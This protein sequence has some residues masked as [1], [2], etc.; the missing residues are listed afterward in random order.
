MIPLSAAQRRLWLID[1][2]EST[3]AAYN[4]PVLLHLHGRVDVAAWRAALVDV[5][6]RHEALRTC[7]ERRAN[8]LIQIIRDPDDI[9]DPLSTARCAPEQLPEAV[10]AAVEYV[11]RLDT[12]P[13]LRAT[14]I[15]TGTHTHTLV[16]LIHHAAADGWS[17]TPLLHDLSTAYTARVA[18]RV[19][20]F[21]P[22]P[23]QYADF[24]L[25]QDQLLGTPADPTSLAAQQL[26]YWRDALNG[27]PH[28]LSLPTDHPRPQRPTY[29]AGH[30]Q[31][32]LSAT[33]TGA[34][35]AL[36]EQTGSTTFMVLQTAL[37]AL[38][39]HLGAGTD[40]PI[41]SLVTGR[42]DDTLEGL[43]GMFVNTVVL[44]NDTSGNPTWRQLLQRLRDTDLAAWTHQDVP[45][46]HV[47]QQLRPP[48]VTGRH[49]LFQTMLVLQNAA[50]RTLDLP[51]LKVIV[52]L[53]HQLRTTKFDLLLICTPQP[54]GE[55]HVTIQF[56]T[57]L[58]E[59][60]TVHA[61]ADRLHRTLRRLT[62]DPDQHIDDEG[63]LLPQEWQR[64]TQE[65]NGNTRFEP[66]ET[67]PELFAA[68]VRSNPD[69]TALVFGDE[70]LTYRELAARANRFA[71]LLL[72]AGVG[73][74]SLVA[75][76][77]PRGVEM[78][79]AI[80]AIH[81]AGAAYL[82][83]DPAYPA[84]RIDYL[85]R[86]AAPHCLVTLDAIRP[87]TTGP[88]SLPTFLLDAE[89]RLAQQS[90]APISAA[91]R[92]VPI[93]PDHAAYVIYTS[94]STGRPKGTVVSHHNVVRLFHDATARFGLGRD[95][96]WALFHSFAFDFSVWEIWGALL[97]G[98]CLVVVPHEVARSAPD[99]LE[100]LVRERVTVLSQTPSA[101]D[102]FNRVDA[103][104]PRPAELA[105]RL[106]VFGGET[107]DFRSVADWSERHPGTR[108]VNGYGPTETTI[109]AT[110]M[111]VPAEL[112]DRRAPSLIGRGLVDLR[113]H[114]LDA[115]LNPVPP[116]VT[117][118]LYVAGDGLT[119]G[120]LGC[121]GLSASRYV[122][123]PF[124]GPGTR[125][126]R[127][128]DLARWS[129]DGQLEY[130]GRADD[131]VKIRGFRIEL[132]EIE[133]VLLEH[134]GLRQAAVLARGENGAALLV[135]Y[136][137]PAATVPGPTVAEL[138]AYLLKRLPEYIVPAVIMKLTAFPLNHNGKVDRAALP[139]PRPG[140]A[141][142]RRTPLT[143]TE[144][145]LSQIFAEVLEV[146]TVSADDNFF[147]LGGHSLLAT[148]LAARVRAV[149][150]R[151]VNVR[152]IFDAPTVARLAKRLAPAADPPRPPLRA[153]PRPALPPASAAQRRLWLIDQLELS[154]TTYNVPILVELRGP[155][156][157]S[158]WRAALTDVIVRH[159]V[160]RT[161][162]G[163]VDDE[164]VQLVRAP[165]EIGDPLTTVL[166]SP[167][168]RSATVAS[169][170]GHVFRLADE[171]PIRATLVSTGPDDHTL[172]LLLHHVAADGA[173]VRPLLTDLSTAYA[174]HTE[175]RAPAFPSLPV[176]Y[177]DYSRWHAELLGDPLEPTSL[178]AKQLAFW[179][180][181]LA[182]M[183][184]ETG[185]PANRLRS[186]YPSPRLG[187]HQS[188]LP[189]ELG[190][191]VAA[192]ADRTGTTVFMV[193][194]T[195][196]TAVLSQLG[197]GDDIAL[198]SVVTG[199]TERVLDDLVGFFVNTV[200]LRTSTAGNPTWLELL[201]RVRSTDL[202]AWANQ[203]VPFDYVVRQ[204][205]HP[206]SAGR[207][208]LFQT[209]LV[210]RS[211]ADDEVRLPGLTG[212]VR[213]DHPVDSIKFDLVVTVSARA[214]DRLHIDLEY[215]ADRYEP[216]SIHHLTDRLHASL[217]TLTEHPH[218]HIDQEGQHAD[219][220]S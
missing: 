1:Q 213:L 168:E 66:A 212:T 45:F 176:Q 196:L 102:E 156:D 122:A 28:E 54:N 116:G 111:E 48:R 65:W 5:L 97:H 160:L 152:D 100:L 18:G 8:E 81:Q 86:D 187:H 163:R 84:D 206:R 60:P 57:D 4:I 217:Q 169:A 191:A 31:L 44:R 127:T 205:R 43:V 106:L 202:S 51:G 201:H 171:L 39:H 192:S 94:G 30:H 92:A 147:E 82:P 11:F 131:Q 128:G 139:A 117:G 17:M 115:A 136:V 32:T 149:L 153:E 35:A 112:A 177:A 215:D 34:V 69:A 194:Q 193:V 70:R 208:P 21:T 150:D 10:T 67:L 157:I 98:G 214:D 146:D 46:D 71:R 118:E 104:Q 144:N 40:I 184:P 125:M 14:L 88:I 151:D 161:C 50:V 15:S 59:P 167:D 109:F 216:R 130:V 77:L 189:A 159:E 200:V 180:Q 207:H 64:L 73:P 145:A 113:I 76:L 198:G 13:P 107:L 140:N 85:V 114:V 175:H 33:L 7:L 53:E 108:L 2:M 165:D 74:E 47:V 132:G 218:H 119:R 6:V 101:F 3:S 91:E 210:Q 137:V 133:S 27:S 142:A 138:R 211:G 20:V 121:P 24:T 183:P 190:A 182:D 29:Q 62:D 61:L 209:M 26:A 129:S 38:L 16:L 143:P 22:L 96:V 166:C 75:V 9:G 63:V 134:P 174:A 36:A 55:L 162:L 204:Q 99:L 58:F 124:D 148:R 23:V 170:A 158:A 126:Y 219:S 42:T 25:W 181:A 220:H 72:H 164:P 80:I 203:D 185:L 197:A 173:S 178:A 179:R 78:I 52:D 12:D 41:G 135:A 93:R 110:F 89:P 195:A 19:P 37:A 155:V 79:V 172:V 186:A 123:S 199:R 49:P 188:T 103:E 83:L 120:Y 90:A 141:P 87:T 68:R 105:L 154:S 56:N 95:D